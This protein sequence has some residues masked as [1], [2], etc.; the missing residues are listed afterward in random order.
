MPNPPLQTFRA[1]EPAHFGF[2]AASTLASQP[3]VLYHEQSSAVTGAG[4]PGTNVAATFIST[5]AANRFQPWLWRDSDPCY[6]VKVPN[7]YDRIHIWPLFIITSSSSNDTASSLTFGT[8]TSYAA[9]FIMPFGLAPQTRGFTTAN[10][11]NPDIHRL[12]DDI[13]ARLNLLPSF[14]SRVNGLWNVLPPYASNFSTSNGLMA[15]GSATNPTSF[16]R[17]TTGTGLGYALPD[18]FSISNAATSAL[19]ESAAQYA[20]G[21]RVL[22]GMGHDFQTLGAEEIVVAPGSS[23]TGM[24][25]NHPG[26]NGVSYRVNYFLMGT[27]LG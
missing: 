1:V 12:P 3:F 8:L 22:I 23:P 6:P 4:S 2:A 7:A 14:D 17:A 27:F 21:G 13:L 5:F 18:D 9:P 11:L 19:S 24:T 15:V 20:T 16:G 25:F 26:T 10:R